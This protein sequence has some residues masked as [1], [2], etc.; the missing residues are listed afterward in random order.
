MGG[1]SATTWGW[2]AACGLVVALGGSNARAQ[3]QYEVLILLANWG[4]VG[5]A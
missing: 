4:D 1:S 3:G 5:D 2:V